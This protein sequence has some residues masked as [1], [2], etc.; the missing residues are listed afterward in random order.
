MIGSDG[1]IPF[2]SPIDRF[3]E[4]EDCSNNTR[5]DVHYFIPPRWSVDDDERRAAE[6]EAPST[7]PPDSS[8]SAGRESAPDRRRSQRHHLVI[9]VNGM[10]EFN[11]GVYL[12]RRGFCEVFKEM[13]VASAF[14]PLPFHYNRLSDEDAASIK[15]E[16]RE[17]PERVKANPGAT[18]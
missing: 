11:D 7:K 10:G 18:F 2:T 6:P 5:F 12:D 14:L 3:I 16:M 9:L 15:R 4:G 8:K 1:V 17:W 13:G